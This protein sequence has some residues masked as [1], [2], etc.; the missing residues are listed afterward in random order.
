MLEHLR[1]ADIGRGALV[2]RQYS[3]LLDLRFELGFVFATW[4]AGIACIG[5]AGLP[6]TLDVVIAVLRDSG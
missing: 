3:A 6:N 2:D 1:V 4:Y 5:V